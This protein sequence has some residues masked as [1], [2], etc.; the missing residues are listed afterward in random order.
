MKQFAAQA[1]VSYYTEWEDHYR[2]E[3]ARAHGCTI[4]DL[5]IN[6]F[7]DLLPGAANAAQTVGALSPAVAVLAVHRRSHV[8]IV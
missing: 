4:Y 2:H 1:I 8:D 7:G 5:Q 6:Y 3:L